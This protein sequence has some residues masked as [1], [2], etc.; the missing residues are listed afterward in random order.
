MTTIKYADND[1]VVHPFQEETGDG[2]GSEKRPVHGL[3]ATLATALT[4]TAARLATLITNLGTLSATPTKLDTLHADLAT[5]LA[6]YV[7]G[8]EALIGTTNTGLATLH[9]DVGTTLH[10]DLTTTI[11]GKLDTLH[12]DLATTLAG[13]VDG[14]E[15]FLSTLAGAVSAARVAVDLATTPTANLATLAGAVSSAKMQSDV[16][17]LPAPAT[18]IFSGQGSVG[19][20]HAA[21]AGSQALKH[22]VWIRNTHATQL[23]YIGPVTVSSSVGYLL[24]PGEEKFLPVANL[25]TVD[26]I[27]SAASTTFC[28]LA[29]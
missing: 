6:A 23:L 9:T 11:A 26:T 8:L 21:L 18:S 13:Y 5:T 27:G 17:T 29:S 24:N 14:L 4:D 16:I 15:G 10:A 20:T 25:A 12:T 1:S 19:T 22:G 28:Y 2:G 3:P 7:D